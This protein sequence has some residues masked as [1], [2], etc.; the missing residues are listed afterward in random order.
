[1]FAFKSL[2]ILVIFSTLLIGA[3]AVPTPNDVSQNN[4]E[5]NYEGMYLRGVFNWW[6]ANEAFRFQRID[7]NTMSVDIELIA[8]GQPY[9]FKLADNTWSPAFNCGLPSE[10]MPLVLEGKQAL[11]CFSDSL[12]LQFIPPE[13]AIYRFEFDTSDSESPALTIRRAN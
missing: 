9:D 12:N 11:Y 8:D 1:M 7:A 6:E 2:R 10:K 4:I 5:K 3:C 13:T